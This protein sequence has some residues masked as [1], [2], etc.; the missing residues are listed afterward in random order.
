MAAEKNRIEVV[1]KKAGFNF[2]IEDKF[3]AGIVLQ[4]TEV[5]SVRANNLNMGDA[6]CVMMDGELY[7]RNMHISEF[8][9]ASF[10]SHEP[11]HDRKLLLT[12]K[13]IKRLDQKAKTKGYTI[14]PIRLFEN[15]R[16]IFKIEIG[17]GQGKKQF[18]KRE[19]LKEKDAKRDLERYK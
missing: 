3:T 11:I 9:Q 18:D 10:V 7:L 19:D 8:K 15:E 12:K 4:G 5:K 2:H 6:Y 16:G 17:I 14:F 13:E 1:N